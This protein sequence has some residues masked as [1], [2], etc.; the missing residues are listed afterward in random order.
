MR[1][2]GTGRR[3]GWL[4]KTR[5]IKTAA[6]VPYGGAWPRARTRKEPQTELDKV[7]ILYLSKIMGTCVKK[8]YSGTSKTTDCGI[9]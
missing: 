2:S 1:K 7:H 8:K 5:G 4:N 3:D 6:P 9:Y